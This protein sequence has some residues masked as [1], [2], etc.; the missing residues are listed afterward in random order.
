MIKNFIK[1]NESKDVL[2]F[3]ETDEWKSLFKKYNRREYIIDHL[4]ALEDDDFT[5]DLLQNFN[6][7]SGI[8]TIKST[9]SISKSYNMS[10]DVDQYKE[11]LKLQSKDIDYLKKILDRMAAAIGMEKKK[12]SLIRAPFSGPMDTNINKD[13]TMIKFYY[14]MD[15]TDPDELKSTKD[16]FQ[17][18]PSRIKDTFNIVVKKL[19]DGGI[20]EEDAVKLLDLSPD[21]TDEEYIYFGFITNDQIRAVAGYD[22]RNDELEFDKSEIYGAIE[23]YKGGYCDEYL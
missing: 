9:I 3:W 1:F 2:S 18:T 5:Y 7:K 19:V 4:H 22:K 15:I 17:L 23:D 21:Y 20:P 8:L 16:K 13:T 14:D 11:F 10:Y 6:Y 12:S